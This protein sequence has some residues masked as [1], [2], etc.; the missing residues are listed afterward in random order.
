M[1][2]L[3]ESITLNGVSR[4]PALE[5]DIRSRVETLHRFHPAITSCRVVVERPHKHHHQG[6]QFVVRLRLAV[7]GADF[8]V[9]HDHSEDVHVA[10]RDA[11]DAARRQLEDHVGRRDGGA[12]SHRA[13][14]IAPGKRRGIPS[15]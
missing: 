2:D 11:F 4:S 7:P 10:L 14:R 9:N 6:G 5:S 3:I 15:D 12:K 1:S 13:A 8:V